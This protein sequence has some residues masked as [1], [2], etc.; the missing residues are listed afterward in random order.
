M[1][2]HHK[3]DV[4]QV[5]GPNSVMIEC[6]TCHGTWDP[7]TWANCFW[8]AEKAGRHE[9]YLPQRMN[10]CG[11]GSCRTEFLYGDQFYYKVG[12][13]GSSVCIPCGRKEGLTKYANWKIATAQSPYKLWTEEELQ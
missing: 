1:R 8:C 5:H 3:G 7:L 2:F 10:E 12:N 4:V 6:A 9:P 13:P 11:M